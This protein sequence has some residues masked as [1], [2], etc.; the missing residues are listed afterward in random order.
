MA[1]EYKKTLLAAGLLFSF[2]ALNAEASLTAYTSD[3]KSLVYDNVTN[4][5]WTGDANLLD[6]LETTLGYNTLIS[7]IIAASPTITDIANSFDTPVNSG[8]HNVTS[9]DFSSGGYANWFGAQAFTG[10]LNS[11]SY[12][13]SKLW[14][15][16]TAGANPQ[17][18]YNQ[19]GTQFGELFY[20]ELGGTAG[21][22]L[23][24]TGNFTNEQFQPSVFWTG[25]ENVSDPSRAW[26]FLSYIGYQSWHSKDVPNYAWVV[27]PGLVSAVPV[28]GTVWLFGSGL[29]GLL[30]L[31]R[32]GRPAN[33]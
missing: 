29:I 11:I 3:G 31:K 12:A 28:P 8:Q 22:A 2:T 14:A 18:G 27:S 19:T 16:P 1:F 17:A 30:G 25:T 10:Y 23:P 4:I 5:T 13:G 32:R 15:L 20:N 26:D 21:N 33:N 24:N 6:T 7:A 9:A